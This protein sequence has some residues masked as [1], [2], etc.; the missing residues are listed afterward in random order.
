MTQTS[1][2]SWVR[3]PAPAPVPPPGRGVRAVRAVAIASCLPYITLKVLWIAGSRVGIPDGSTLLD[4][5]IAMAIGNGLSVAL[6]AAVVVLALLLTQPWGRRVPAWLLALPMWVATGLL[7]PI[8]T[9]YPLQLAVTAF[10]GS[11][12]PSAGA[13]EP[14]L[15]EWVFAVVYGGFIVQGLALGALFVRY[16]HRR[17]GHLWRGPLGGTAAAGDPGA[18]GPGQA[19]GRRRGSARAAAVAGSLLALFPGAMHLLWAG[20]STTGLGAER[21]A[22]RT[23][24]FQVLEGVSAGFAVLAV[25]ATLMLAFRRAGRPPLKAA[26]AGAWAG[27]GVLGCWGGWLLLASL[28]PTDGADPHTPTLVL[29]YAVSMVAGFLLLSGVVSVLRRRAA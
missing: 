25:T 24:D 6:D 13:D 14:F 20:G 26:V 17:W 4:D 27:S 1:T 16:A 5:R 10:S 7:A 15:H 19:S 21:I 11:G 9:G 18:A 29:T 12:S 28:M 3:T 23:N 2:A 8:M 22:G